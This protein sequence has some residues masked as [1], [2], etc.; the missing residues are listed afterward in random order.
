MTKRVGWIVLLIALCD[1]FLMAA[2]AQRFPYTEIDW[3]AYMEQVEQAF[4]RG[5]TDYRHIRGCTGPLVYP[6]GF[7]WFY[8]FL[9]RLT[10][11]GKKR[12]NAQAVFVLL[13]ALGIALTNAAFY[14]AAQ[15]AKDLQKVSE[16]G[17]KKRKQ[18][19]LRRSSLGWITAC[20]VAM[21]SRRV[22]SIYVLRLFNDGL[23]AVLAQAS[24]LLFVMARSHR[25]AHPPW[26][27]IV[28]AVACLIYSM[29]VSVKMNALLYAP[30][31]LVLLWEAH[32]LPSALGYVI[33]VCGLW[34]VAIGWRYLRAHPWS[35]LS[36]AFDLGRVFELRWSV[37][38]A[39]LPEWIFVHPFLSW[40]LLL[41]HGAMLV[42]FGYRAGVPQWLQQRQRQHRKPVIDACR[43]AVLLWTSNLIGIAFARTLHYQFLAWMWWSL[44]FLAIFD[45]MQQ[46]GCCRLSDDLTALSWRLV[47]V[48]LVEVVFN[49]YPPRCL[50]SLMLHIAHGLLL[51]RIWV[52]L[53]QWRHS[54]PGR[55]LRM[56][57]KMEPDQIRK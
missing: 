46:G 18:P 17:S 49:V 39:C 20:V 19:L 25:T 47:P 54:L 29:A 52:G 35:Y 13:H 6:A 16:E 57:Y 15:D 1:L 43:A 26:S 28:D 53:G 14:L 45:W 9:Y 5:E 36:K 11:A 24:V 40:T 4:V 8:Y 48:L 2:I 56:D 7:L 34:Q 55:G 31:V 32:G 41:L 51:Y 50:T 3:K 27:R 38:F 12:S 10:D 30:A 42:V 37:S 33:G 22:A 23:E 21:G 44:P